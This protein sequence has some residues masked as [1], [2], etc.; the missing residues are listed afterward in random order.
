MEKV[1]RNAIEEAARPEVLEAFH[2]LESIINAAPDLPLY[3][4]LSIFTMASLSSGCAHCT[5]HGAYALSLTG[6]EVDKIRDLWSFETSQHFSEADRAALR[7]ANL[8]G[9]STSSV[10]PENREELAKHFTL[11]QIADILAIVALSGFLNRWNG[12]LGVVTEAAPVA[13]AEKHLSDLGWRIGIH[14]G[15]EA[16]RRGA[17]PG[18]EPLK[19]AVQIE[20]ERL[21]RESG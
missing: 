13:F 18:V 15:D 14:A 2:N 8:A 20:R 4:K 19:A 9:L 6:S 16:E 21:A 12:S 7:F 3:L 10:R 1:N 11:Q 5:A 17:R